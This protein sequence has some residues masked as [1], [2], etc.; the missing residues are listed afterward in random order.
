MWIIYVLCFIFGG[1]ISC[2]VDRLSEFVS[3]R[4][5]YSELKFRSSLNTKILTILAALMLLSGLFVISY[6]VCH[7]K[8]H[9]EMT[10]RIERIE[11]VVGIDT[12]D[13]TTNS[14]AVNEKSQE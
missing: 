8:T 13:V 7:E 12:L 4:D 3:K 2:L 9:K 10:D 11:S 1:L 6:A 14:C 5:R